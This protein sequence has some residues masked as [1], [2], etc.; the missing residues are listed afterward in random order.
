MEK[1]C[2]SMIEVSD[3]TSKEEANLQCERIQ[4]HT[5]PNFANVMLQWEEDGTVKTHYPKRGTA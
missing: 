2:E 3:A 5:G 1:Q 4:G